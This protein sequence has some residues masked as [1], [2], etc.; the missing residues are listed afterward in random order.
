[1][2]NPEAPPDRR[3]LIVDDRPEIRLLIR[4]RLRMI[5]DVE[6]VG[7]ASNAAEA[8]ILVYALAPE[9]VIL[10]LDMPVMRGDEAIPKIRE[11]AP[12]VRILL[13]TGVDEAE[14]AALPDDAQPDAT[15]MKGG[16]LA[17]LVVQLRV[18]L[19]MGPYDM[20]RLVLGPIPLDQAVTVF[21]TWVGLNVRILDSLARGDELAGAKLSGA[22]LEELQALIGVYAHLGDNLQKA[23]RNGDDEV[24]P[25]IHLL[26][27]TAAAARRALVAFNHVHLPEFYAAWH[28]VV[29]EKAAHALEEMR[30][31]LM[32]ALPV[33]SADETESDPVNEIVGALPS[34]N[35]RH[36][37][38]R[39]AAA[40]ADRTAAAIDRSS[41][42]ED[43]AVASIDELTGSYVRGPGHVELEREITRA[44]RTNKPLAVAFLDVDGLKAV[45]DSRGHEAGDQLLQRVVSVLRDQ[46]R[47]YDIIVRQGGDEFVC[48]LPGFGLDEANGRMVAV[49]DSLAAGGNPGSVSVGLAVLEEADTLQTLISRADDALYATRASRSDDTKTTRS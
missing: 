39:D 30:D 34:G 32:D 11:L 2:K 31:L 40:A 19:D 44:R 3:V 16:S 5:H 33:S 48:A 46:L 38:G 17:E 15:V 43:R 45:N 7:E 47:G 27:T 22:T 9:V 21:D 49:Q 4:A 12:G 37:G 23:A 18:L 1:M 35:G 6:V 24:V 10:D 13:Y 8:L 20:L 42:A 36:D 28:Y 41:A 26:R 14:V 25:I 29:P